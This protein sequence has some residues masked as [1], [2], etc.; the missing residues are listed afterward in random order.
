MKSLHKLNTSIQ[1]VIVFV[2][3]KQIS[4]EKFYDEKTSILV[5]KCFQKPYRSSPVFWG[6]ISLSSYLCI[7]GFFW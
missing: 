7:A 6:P 2:I 3:W 5:K 1:M 4:Y